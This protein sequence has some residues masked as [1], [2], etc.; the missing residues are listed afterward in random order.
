MTLFST[1]KIT[2]KLP[3][4]FHLFLPRS[5]ISPSYLE[6]IIRSGAKIAPVPIPGNKQKQ[7][8]YGTQNP[9]LGSPIPLFGR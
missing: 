3:P 1:S 6:Y 8:I 7:K 5:N 4:K 2:P 9:P